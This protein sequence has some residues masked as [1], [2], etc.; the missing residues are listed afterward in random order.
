MLRLV[1]NNH[2]LWYIYRFGTVTKSRMSSWVNT[3]SLLR[4]TA[5][6]RC[7]N[8]TSSTGRRAPTDRSFRENYT[9]KSQP[10]GEWKT[11]R[12]QHCCIYL[13]PI[14]WRTCWYAHACFVTE[15]VLF[16]WETNNVTAFENF[17]L[18]LIICWC[19]NTWWLYLIMR[20]R[21]FRKEIFFYPGVLPLERTI[22]L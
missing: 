6:A 4:K 16:E 20:S 14:R 5:P 9:S 13:L 3:S 15:W 11:T 10:P 1:P 18:F 12:V 2:I 22:L 7:S 21:V 19:R 17:Y 8:W